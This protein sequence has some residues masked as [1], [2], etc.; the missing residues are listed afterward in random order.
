[1]QRH[2]PAAET[3]LVRRIVDAMAASGRRTWFSVWALSF[4]VFTLT[5]HWWT[6]QVTDAIGASWPA[7]QLAHHGTFDLTGGP[8]VLN[9]DGIVEQGDRVVAL[10]TMGVVLIAVP[11]NF[12]LDWTGLS[13]VQVG[14]L[15]ASLVT[16]LAM[17]NVAV[18]LRAFTTPR[19]AVLGAL[20]LAFGTGMWT[21]ASAELWTHG[22]TALWL[23][24]GLVL[25]SRDRLLLAGCALAPA[26]LTRPH[27]SLAIAVIG[28]WVG[29]SR[30][31]LRPVLAL[32]IPAIGAVCLLVGWN[33]WY[34]GAPSIGGPYHGAIATAARPVSEGMSTFA[35]NVAGTLVSGWCGALLYSPVLV[36]L[37]VALPYGWRTAP[38]FV[39]G[40]A[41]GGVLYLAVQL[42]V[43]TF[44]G[45]GT[46]YGNRLVL[47][48]LVLC[49][50]LAA[51][52]YARWSHG[53]PWRV[54]VTT[55]LAAVSVGIHAVGALLGDYR[56]GGDFSDWTTWYPVVVVRASGVVGAMVV[57]TV[58]L[59][60][61][62]VVRDSVRAAQA[63]G[64]QARLELEQPTE[65]PV[66]ERGR[67][68]GRERPGEL[69]G[70]VDDHGVG[71]VV[72]P[73]QLE[74]AQPEDGPVDG[75]HP[76]QGPALGVR[77]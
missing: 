42:R 8:G 31:S 43:D 72:P 54:A 76:V 68:V 34:F 67:V 6:G 15:T 30:R 7:W 71:Y 73:E 14:A 69:D 22:P 17:A 23:S 4:V 47:E 25:L 13:A 59:V 39:R 46:L 1:V 37:A 3:D 75:G 48:L 28:L 32:G 49:T 50:P 11:L 2:A 24:L 61:A 20:L 33:A 16:S 18:L 27:L 35:V 38:A 77:R 57:P 12:L 60:V 62:V 21:L 40:A 26:L 9:V 19:R 74:G 36:A 52:G 44:R 29:A 70:L 64:L 10:R 41:V 58:L 65:Q 63:S 45:G 5:A 55:S 66:D 51:L 53:R 56:V